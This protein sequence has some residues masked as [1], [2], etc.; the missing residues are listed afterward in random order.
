MPV[1]PAGDSSGK[2]LLPA[3]GKAQAGIP[4]YCFWL[5]KR[6]DREETEAR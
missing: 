6:C 5:E 2:V 3:S 4:V 1:G